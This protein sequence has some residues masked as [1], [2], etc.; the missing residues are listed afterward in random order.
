M[1]CTESAGLWRSGCLYYF[2]DT[3]FRHLLALMVVRGWLTDW[4]MY[5][6]ESA[7]LWR[8]GSLHHF[9]DALFRHLPALIVLHG[10]LNDWSG[11]RAGC[12]VPWHCGSL[13]QL[14]DLSSHHPPAVLV[15]CGLLTNW[16]VCRECSSLTWWKDW[17]PQPTLLFAI[18]PPSWR[19]SCVWFIDLLAG[20][21]G[22]RF[23]D[24]VERLETSSNS[25]IRH[26]S[27]L[28]AS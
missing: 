23:S 19:L 7:D 18:P 28:L 14:S 5:C 17:K 6:T 12:A 21:Q 15:V 24:M 2:C 22:V 13:N 11:M 10:W 26:P 25:L 16:L 8:G 20:V 4:L 3:L 27:T 9:S 1:Y